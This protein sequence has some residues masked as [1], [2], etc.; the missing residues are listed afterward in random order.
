MAWDQWLDGLYTT[1]LDTVVYIVLV[2]LII[3]VAQKGKHCIVY[4]TDDEV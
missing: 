3:A 2:K 1:S 4:Y